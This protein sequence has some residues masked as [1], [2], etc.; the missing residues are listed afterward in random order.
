MSGS[1]HTHTKPTCS[2]FALIQCSLVQSWF[3]V[4]LLLQLLQTH[5]NPKWTQQISVL[6]PVRGIQYICASVQKLARC[7]FGFCVFLF[8][9]TYHMA[10]K[11]PEAQFLW[12]LVCNMW[13][14]TSGWMAEECSS[15][16]FCFTRFTY[17]WQ[18]ATLMSSV[19]GKEKQEFLWY[20][21][22]LVVSRE[23]NWTWISYVF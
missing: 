11:T 17:V 19:K 15:V 5:N 23:S 2:A 22:M 14:C 12:A 4:T 6:L 21:L 1:S 10:R 20:W 7:P 18:R 9:T 16:M 8:S 3:S 13:L